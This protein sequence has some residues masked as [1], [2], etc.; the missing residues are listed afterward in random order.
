MDPIDFVEDLVALISEAAN[1]ILKM[2]GVFNNVW[3]LLYQRVKPALNW[4]LQFWAVS[5]IGN[6]LLFNFILLNK[7]FFFMLLVSFHSM[8]VYLASHHFMTKHVLQSS[9]L[10]LVF[11]LWFYDDLCLSTFVLSPSPTYV[12]WV[13]G[14]PV[15]EFSIM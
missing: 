9:I 10:S 2:P 13:L 12:P 4:W 5:V 7:M 1:T 11:W 3:R 8:Y 14:H 6:F 15:S